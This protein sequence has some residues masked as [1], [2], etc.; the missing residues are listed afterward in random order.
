MRD[1]MDKVVTERPRT[2]GSPHKGAK[3]RDAKVPWDEKPKREPMSHGRGNKEFTDLIGPL[4]R[5]LEKNV[6]RPWNKVWSEVKAS[7]TGTG[8]Q[9]QHLRGHVLG[10]VEEH[11]VMVDGK[12]T[13]ASGRAGSNEEMN[14]IDCN[15]ASASAAVLIRPD[16]KAALTRV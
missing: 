9:H 8:M 3:K 14:L 2:K 11:I 16:A 1:D 15:K 13:T 6:G 10:D 12:P 7:M 5:Y 4:H